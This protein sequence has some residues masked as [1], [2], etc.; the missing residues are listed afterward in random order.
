[1]VFQLNSQTFK[2][3]K[4]MM[5]VQW[6]SMVWQLARNAKDKYIYNIRCNFCI[7]Y[8]TYTHKSK[9]RT[10]YARYLYY[11]ISVSSLCHMCIC[12]LCSI[13]L[14]LHSFLQNFFKNANTYNSNAKLLFYSLNFFILKLIVFIQHISIMFLKISPGRILK[15]Y[16]G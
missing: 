14:T 7:M 9:Y 16:T 6:T 4:I 8:I 2:Y 15:S 12:A 11:S 3:I 5:Y 1:M 13:R 10:Q